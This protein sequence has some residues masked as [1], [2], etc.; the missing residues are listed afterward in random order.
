[1]TITEY[2]ERRGSKRASLKHHSA[3]QDDLIYID[4]IRQPKIV[5]GNHKGMSMHSQRL[6]AASATHAS[7]LKYMKKS[8]KLNIMAYLSNMPSVMYFS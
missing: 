1:M 2:F 8:N 3:A 4:D 6:I 5:H 7:R